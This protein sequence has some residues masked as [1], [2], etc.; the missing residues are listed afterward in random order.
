MSI[1]EITV[2]WSKKLTADRRPGTVARDWRAYLNSRLTAPV[3]SRE[4]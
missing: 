2:A 3:V 4:R 1:P